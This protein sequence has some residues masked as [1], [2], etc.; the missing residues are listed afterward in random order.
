MKQTRN[1]YC[2]K[3]IK[4]GKKK[5]SEE[6]KIKKIGIIKER[7]FGHEYRFIFLHPECAGIEIKTTTTP[8]TEKL[9]ISN[10]LRKI[11][12]KLRKVHREIT[13]LEVKIKRNKIE[14]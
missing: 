13:K 4:E 5:H 6:V 10:E 1:A 12:E 2:Y 7:K 11:K 8:L 14:V 9:I 3:C